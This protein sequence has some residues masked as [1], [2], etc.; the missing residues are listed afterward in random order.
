MIR[1]RE[2]TEHAG[3]GLVVWWFGV[4]AWFWR[5]SWVL[6]RRVRP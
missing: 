3:F 5:W 2:N 1:W 6:K 4:R